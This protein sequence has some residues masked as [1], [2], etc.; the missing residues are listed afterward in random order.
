MYVKIDPSV[1]LKEF[2]HGTQFSSNQ[3]N[4]RVFYG[5]YEIYT[6]SFSK[7]QSYCKTMVSTLF[8]LER[9]VESGHQPGY[10]I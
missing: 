6:L 7:C 5:R 8:L 3:C 10:K 4:N 9:L 1:N 2:T